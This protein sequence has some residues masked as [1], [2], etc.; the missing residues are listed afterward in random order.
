MTHGAPVDRIPLLLTP[1]RDWTVKHY[2]LRTFGAPPSRAVRTFTRTCTV[3]A[4]CDTSFFVCASSARAGS[5]VMDHVYVLKKPVPT[6]AAD[7]SGAIGD[8][9]EQ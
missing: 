1:D 3:C 4:H 2:E 7:D 6:A 8:L 5:S 9:E